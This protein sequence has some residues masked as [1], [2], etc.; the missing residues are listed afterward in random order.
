MLEQ[1]VGEAHELVLVGAQEPDGVLVGVLD[2][3]AD[4]VVDQR[5]GL[6]GDPGLGGDELA[7]ALGEA[8]LLD[9]LARHRVR[10]LQ[11]VGGAGGDHAV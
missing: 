8:E 7:G 10:L 1:R 9:G 11:V 4:L 2:E 6:V 3:A 5:D